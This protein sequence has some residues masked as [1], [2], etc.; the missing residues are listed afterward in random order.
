VVVRDAY[1]ALCEAKIVLWWALQKEGKQTTAT[2]FDGA[3]FL[4]HAS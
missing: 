1:K 4:W 3:A 2:L